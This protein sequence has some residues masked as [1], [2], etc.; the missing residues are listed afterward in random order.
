MPCKCNGRD[1]HG[2]PDHDADRSM[3]YAGLAEPPC[4]AWWT[5]RPSPPDESQEHHQEEPRQGRL[6][7]PGGKAPAVQVGVPEDQRQLCLKAII[8]ISFRQRV[9]DDAAGAPRLDLAA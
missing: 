3:A 2:A 9:V 5:K 7:I 4:P 1:S 6:R 8:E